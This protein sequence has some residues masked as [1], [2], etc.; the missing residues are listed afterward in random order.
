MSRDFKPGYKARCLA[1]KV[2]KGVQITL[3]GYIKGVD[4]NIITGYMY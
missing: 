2:T 3:K 1:S 4:M